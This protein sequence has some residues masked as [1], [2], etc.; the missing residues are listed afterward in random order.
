MEPEG[1]LLHF[2]KPTNGSHLE[3][4][5]SSAYYHTILL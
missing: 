5:E 4:G 1:S 3:L 2:K